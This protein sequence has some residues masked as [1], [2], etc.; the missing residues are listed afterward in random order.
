ML[1]EDNAGDADLVRFM[2][3]ECQPRV[4]LHVA[5]DGV[6][7]SQF[8]H[9]EGK[10]ENVPTPDLILLDLNLP[11]RNGK[12]LLRE[13]KETPWLRMIPAILLS[14]SN[15]PRDIQEGYEAGATAFICKP[16]DL[17]E[18]QAVMAKLVDFWFNIVELAH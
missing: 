16:V 13:I 7:G 10:F 15:N 6:E 9:K 3:R 1:V 18:Y 12:E 2:L 11:R 14:S 17:E 4:Q 8:L 5:E